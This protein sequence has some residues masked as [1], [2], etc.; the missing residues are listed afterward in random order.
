[1]AILEL[2]HLHEILQTLRRNRLRTFLTACG[3]FWGVFMLVVMLGFGRGLEKAVEEDMGFFAI[4]NI[5]FRAEQTSKPYD[6]RQAGRRIWLTLDDVAAINQVPGIQVAFGRNHMFGA[7]AYR[8]FAGRPDRSIDCNVTGDYPEIMLTDSSVITRGRF[9]NPI[10]IKEARK[11]AVI[12]SRV[13]EVLFDPGE[14]PIGQTV[15]AG[16]SSFQVVGIIDSAGFGQGRQRDFFNSRMMV[17]RPNLARILGLGERVT[18]IPAIVDDAHSAIDLENNVKALLKARHH[19]A[20][21]D[22]R[23]IWS[24]NREKTWKQFQGLFFGIR[25]LSWVVGV[26]T[27]LA[28]AI[29]VSNIMMIAVAERTKEIGIRKA[30]G[31]TPLSIMGQIVAEATM[32][33]GLAGYL[34]LV[35]GVGVLEL[36]AKIM[37]AMPSTGNGPRFFSSPELDL[38][39]A[40]AAALFLTVAG[41]IAGLAPARA[42][43]AV[44]PV[45]ALAH[46]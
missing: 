30:I 28:G 17:P 24:F 19:V 26:L 20:P 12:G 15:R 35:A 29:G 39:K 46:E 38:G 45:E 18:S 2:D 10:D 23:A 25:A 34:G 11:V 36:A 6:G 5:G 40:I 9:L 16:N 22:E 14:D 37:K 7:R 1:M 42:A 4:N 44:R 3:I 31:A 33:T 32:L 21:D 13:A 8:T 41:A 43:V 27:L